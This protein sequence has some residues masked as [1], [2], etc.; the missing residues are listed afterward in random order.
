MQEGTVHSC[1]FL[2]N[3][4]WENLIFLSFWSH[5]LLIL[6]ILVKVKKNCFLFLSQC[7][8]NLQIQQIKFS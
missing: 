1:L 5:L 2:N 8:I 6:W 4:N 3:V 7:S